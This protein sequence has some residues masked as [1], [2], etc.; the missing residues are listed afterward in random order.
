MKKIAMIAALAATAFALPTAASAQDA[1]NFEGARVGGTVGYADGDGVDAVTYGALLGFD[2]RAA[3]NVIIGFTGEYGDSADTG[4]D[5]SLGGRIGGVFG[6]NMIYVTGAYTN[7][8]VEDT[9]FELD[10]YRV[11]A[12]VER[13][14]GRYFAALE[15][16]YSDYELGVDGSK[17]Q[18]V[19]GLRF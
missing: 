7:L 16:S 10:G 8:Q 9:N 5:L 17:G 2:V 6:A 1:S 12:G 15:G 4:R 13:S 18:L 11:G 19:V 14:Y 3:D